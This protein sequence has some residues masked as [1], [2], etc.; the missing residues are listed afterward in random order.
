MS[1]IAITFFA[2]VFLLVAWTQDFLLELV[3]ILLTLSAIYHVGYALFNTNSNNRKREKPKDVF[4]PQTS[5]WSSAHF[6]SASIQHCINK[7]INS[8]KHEDV[9]KILDLENISNH[10]LFICRIYMMYTQ[11]H[12]EKYNSLPLSV[13][14]WNNEEEKNDF[15]AYCRARDHEFQ[16]TTKLY[17]KRATSYGSS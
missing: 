16:N 9:L 6:D 4:R 5:I 12:V 13:E 14:R 3:L 15:I 11:W 10:E 2:M 7:L 8:Y 17:K 1:S